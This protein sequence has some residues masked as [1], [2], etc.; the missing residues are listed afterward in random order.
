MPK[1]ISDFG[2]T[3]KEAEEKIKDLATAADYS[4]KENEMKAEPQDES[5]IMC[6]YY[7]GENDCPGPMGGERHYVIK[8][9]EMVM[10]H[11]R[12][13]ERSQTDGSNIRIIV[14]GGSCAGGTCR[15]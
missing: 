2:I 5:E 3:M 10:A 6:Y 14:K 11:K 13:Y 8:N 9:G 15:R 1:E 7:T 4:A 12:C